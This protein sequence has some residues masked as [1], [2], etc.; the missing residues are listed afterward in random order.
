MEAY[1]KKIMTLDS[2]SYNFGLKRVTGQINDNAEAKRY[3]IYKR[4]WENEA[5]QKHIAYHCLALAAEFFLLLLSTTS[6]NSFFDFSLP[7][8]LLLFLIPLTASVF[9]SQKRKVEIYLK[10][11]TVLSLVVHFVIE[12]LLDGQPYVTW[13]MALT[14]LYQGPAMIEFVFGSC[15]IGVNL[16]LQVVQ[17]FVY[18][19]FNGFRFKFLFKLDIAF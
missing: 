5:Y 8:R 3:S 11:V 2:S 15:V 13:N 18:D 1:L 6:N 4:K 9:E 12:F 17:L 10:L 7:Y 14:R 16:V 19:T